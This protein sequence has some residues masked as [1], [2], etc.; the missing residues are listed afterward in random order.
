MKV[1]NALPDLPI[2]LS[3]PT[4]QGDKQINV[5]FV[6]DCPSQTGEKNGGREPPRVIWLQVIEDGKLRLLFLGVSESYSTCL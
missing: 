6:A 4:T 5:L 1:T 3:H 2:V